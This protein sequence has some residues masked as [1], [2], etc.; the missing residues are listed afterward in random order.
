M[1]FPRFLRDNCVGI[2]SH[3]NH[4]SSSWATTQDHFLL[5]T[6]WFK[7]KETKFL[8]I[9]W[10]KILVWRTRLLFL[11]LRNTWH[12]VSHFCSWLIVVQ[13]IYSLTSPFAFLVSFFS[14]L[15]SVCFLFLKFFFYF[16]NSLFSFFL[17]FKILH[18]FRYNYEVN[19]SVLARSLHK[20]ACDWCNS[21]KEIPVVVQEIHCSFLKTRWHV[22]ARVASRSFLVCFHNV[23]FFWQKCVG[24]K[25]PC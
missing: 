17:R 25:T 7:H 12:W 22:K 10:L 23:T 13:H 4:L 24:K 3:L 6:A 15:F 1:L 16:N 2:N 11:S 18:K 5:P 9:F 20:W 19:Q 21:T 14:I 8:Y